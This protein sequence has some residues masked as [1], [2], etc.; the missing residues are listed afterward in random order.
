MQ[1]ILSFTSFLHK[2]QRCS[3]LKQST[4]NQAARW[5]ALIQCMPFTWQMTTWCSSVSNGTPCKS[6][7]GQ[8]CKCPCLLYFVHS[9][10]RFAGGKD[11]STKAE[12]DLD[13]V[14]GTKA[15]RE[16]KTASRK[17][18]NLLLRYSFY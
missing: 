5:T 15:K 18:M 7:Y 8:L 4:A 11:L 1:V 12:K 16:D 13:C 10:S 9:Y 6:L 3:K 2:L 17:V 14:F